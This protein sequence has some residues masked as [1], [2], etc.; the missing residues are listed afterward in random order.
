M[1]CSNCGAPGET[2]LTVCVKCGAPLAAHPYQSPRAPVS[3]PQPDSD[4]T[5]YAGF[6]PRAA[7]FIID[8]LIV[9]FGLGML[10][11]LSVGLVRSAGA[12]A[13][14]PVLVL[15]V[16]AWLYYA[17]FESSRLQGTPGKL[18][19]G[20]R[21]TNRAGEPLGFGAATGRCFGH[22][23]SNL[24]LGVGYA[25]VLFTQR[26]QTLHD[27]MAGALVVRKVFAPSEV[28]SAGPAP[29]QPVALSVLATVA[30]V[31]CGPF[32]IGILAAIAIP[33]YQDYTIRAQ[34]MEGMN[35]AAAY[36]AAVAEAVA[37]G[38]E[39]SA[40]STQSLDLR[41]PAAMR[42]VEQMNVA[43]GA[44][45]IRYGMA[46]HRAIAGRSL[47]LIPGTNQRHDV[48]WVCGHHSAPAD[49]TLA[50]EDGAR[51]TSIPDRYLPVACRT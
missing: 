26:R 47:I 32:G 38:Q 27:L 33:A 4:S 11:G 6:W 45:E 17:I 43:S 29:R 9:M 21:V 40:M 35:G 50:F 20:L 5:P 16:A 34:V 15:T 36:K 10:S 31:L 37:R 3:L 39:F 12:P 25:L 1:Y 8:Y 24:T 19:L 28:A 48:V 13:S 42:Y 49:V 14:L 51:Y 30:I 18:A 41:S 7:A 23:V 22:I 2:G 46:A 44:I